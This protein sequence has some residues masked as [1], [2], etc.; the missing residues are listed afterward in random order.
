MAKRI[1]KV[2]ASLLSGLL[3]VLGFNAC[4]SKGA[5]NVDEYGSPSATYKALGTV[6]DKETGKPVEGI[7]VVMANEY[8]RGSRAMLKA[9]SVYADPGTDEPDVY[10]LDTVYTDRN[11]AFDLG[12]RDDLRNE[13]LIVF[14]DLDGNFVPVRRKIEYKDSDFSGKTGL[15]QGEATK[16]MGKVELVRT[17]EE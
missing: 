11:G 16:D 7:R 14:E 5:D 15:Y 10:G 3:A 8:K 1:T 12:D 2:Y 9:D 4:G 13:K 17:E 6:V